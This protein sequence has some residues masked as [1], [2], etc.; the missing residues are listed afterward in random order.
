MKR[1]DS[2]NRYIIVCI[3]IIAVL[4]LSPVFVI[5][6]RNNEQ[7]KERRRALTE[8]V[9]TIDSQNYFYDDKELDGDKLVEG[10]MAE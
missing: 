8:L 5:N 3:V 6:E 9:D 10:A 7:D 4:S 1:P 2:N